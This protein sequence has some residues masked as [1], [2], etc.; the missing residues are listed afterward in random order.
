MGYGNEIHLGPG[1]GPEESPDSRIPFEAATEVFS[2]P[3]HVTNENYHIQDQGEQR[4]ATI[5]LT[6]N[7]LL[8]LVVFVDRGGTIHIISARKADK[9]EAKIY[10]AHIEN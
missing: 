6:L 8:L 7:V 2:D 1:K 9:Y 10:T 3:N 4:Y 5:G